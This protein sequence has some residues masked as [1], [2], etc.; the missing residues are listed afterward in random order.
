MPTG[1]ACSSPFRTGGAPEHAEIRRRG[2]RALGRAGCPD[3]VA[4]VDVEARELIIRVGWQVNRGWQWL[5]LAVALAVS[6]PTGVQ[7]ASIGT[8]NAEDVSLGEFFYA[9]EAARELLVWGERW[10]CCRALDEVRWR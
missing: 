1:P 2:A 3:A 6:S 5:E 7:V 8:L 4:F 10:H 9:L